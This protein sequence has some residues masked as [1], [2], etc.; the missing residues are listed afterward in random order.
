MAAMARAFSLRWPPTRAVPRDD[1]KDRRARL[2]VAVFA[3]VLSACAAPLLW[4]AWCEAGVFW[5]DEILQTLE[6]GHRFAFGYGLVPWEFRD[7]VRSWL[8]P[9]LIGVVMKAGALCGV[10][11]G[12]GLARLVKTCIALGAVGG[13]YATMRL[14]ERFGGLLAASLA[15]V[16]Y[17]A[18]P[19]VVYFGTRSSTD[20]MSVPFV[21]FGVL[22]LASPKDSPSVARDRW[23]AG[24]LL[25]L[26][27][28]ARTQNA[29]IVVTALGVL[30]AVRE[31][32]AAGT[33]VLGAAAALALGGILD[34][35]TWGAPFSSSIAYVR[36]N[37][38]EGRASAFGTEPML[39]Y[40]RTLWTSTGWPILVVA[41]GL[42]AATLRARSLVALVLVFV[43]AHVLIPHKE[44]RFLMPILPVAL[45]GSAVGTALILDRLLKGRDKVK[46]GIVGATSLGI[47]VT[48][49]FKSA[50]ATFASMGYLDKQT[51]P[52]WH[53]DEPAT[54]LFSRVGER[55]DACGVVYYGRSGRDWD[56]T[57][58][59]SYLHRDVPLY[60]ARDGSLSPYANYF[61]APHGARVPNDYEEVEA[62]DT[63]AIFRREGPC[64][65]A[66]DWY[67]RESE[68]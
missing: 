25:G 62:R 20:D 45:A 11:S 21:A 15:G 44:L 34:W 4:A 31:W 13:G 41:I 66:P 35:L 40:A 53:F 6:Q 27:T 17:G 54:L 1:D 57:G 5:P 48:G 50:S 63:F 9:G 3:S 64:A 8:L 30:L 58:T 23:C 37:L 24:I 16:L 61:V 26:A 52:A 22:L 59:F 14:A 65:P 28:V 19:L 29:L 56:H 47:A 51:T 38:I 46:W 68:K 67:S 2:R 49:A 12:V 36:F 32:R 33:F 18:A 7:G 10:H 55:G 43:V 42:I 60:H 39:Y